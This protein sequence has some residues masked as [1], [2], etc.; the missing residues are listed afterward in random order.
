M[1]EDIRLASPDLLMAVREFFQSL[2][3]E[4]EV[5]TVTVDETGASTSDPSI[6]LSAVRTSTK[7]HRVLVTPHL[8]VDLTT[9]EQTELADAIAT[10][11]SSREQRDQD[12]DGC[13]RPSNNAHERTQCDILQVCRVV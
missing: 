7:L 13:G 2:A 9:S 8:Q 12:F 6:K 3:P 1:K 5:S 11:A 4:W 10:L